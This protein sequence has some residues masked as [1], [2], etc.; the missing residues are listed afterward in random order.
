M[1]ANATN[2]VASCDYGD[3]VWPH[4]FLED[5]NPN[6]E[7]S[8][9]RSRIDA[10]AI[11]DVVRCFARDDEDN[12]GT[13]EEEVLTTFCDRA[14]R[15]IQQQ[16]RT[17]WLDD[18]QWSPYYQ[19]SLESIETQTQAATSATLSPVVNCQE[20][21]Y[22]PTQLPTGVIVQEHVAPRSHTANAGPLPFRLYKSSLSPR[23]LRQHLDQKVCHRDQSFRHL[24]TKFSPRA[25]PLKLRNI[26]INYYIQRF[27]HDKLPDADRRLM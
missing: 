5:R 16:R 25:N 14:L 13:V 20:T 17:A 27:G 2:P 6:E 8:Y 22:P 23:M 24:K 4:E 21:R 11:Q 26:E 10:G 9:V 18:R 15:P 1:S 3:T 12:E 7:V 19:K